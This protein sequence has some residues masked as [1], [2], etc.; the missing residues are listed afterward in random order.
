PR[1][2]GYLEAH[3]TGTAL[4]DPIEVGAL[5]A[6]FA[7]DR[8]ADRPLVIGSG[9]TNIG[10][11]EAAAGVAGL[12]KAALVLH[13]AEI[14]PHHHF[15]HPNPNIP[16]DQLPL[17]VPTRR[18]PWPRGDSPRMAGVSSFGMSGANAHIVLEEAS[19]PGSVAE[20]VDRPVHVI[21]LSARS[22]QG[23]RTL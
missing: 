2:I 19:R 12:I 21:A 18:T 16:W 23:V 13:R 4:G 3:G 6:V 11:L 1:E 9:K 22:E 10:H 5:V 20:G 8:P 7:P 15:R 17:V 14:P